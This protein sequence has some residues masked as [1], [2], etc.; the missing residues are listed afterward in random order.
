MKGIEFWRERSFKQEQS[1]QKAVWDHV[2]QKDKLVHRC[3]LQLVRSAVASTS[4]IEDFFWFDTILCINN[5]QLASWKSWTLYLH[6]QDPR[7]H[8]KWLQPGQGTS[9]GQSGSQAQFPDFWG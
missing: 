7:G 6:A 4:K 2:V 5:Q 8:S 3:W 9:A 1:K